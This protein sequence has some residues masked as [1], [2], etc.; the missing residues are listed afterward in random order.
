MTFGHGVGKGNG[1]VAVKMISHNH[2]LDQTGGFADTGAAGSLDAI[3]LP[4]A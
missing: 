1:A 4:Q 3:S 2:A